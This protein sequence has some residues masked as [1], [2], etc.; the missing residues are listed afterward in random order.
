MSSTLRCRIPS[1]LFFSAVRFQLSSTLMSAKDLEKIQKSSSIYSTVYLFHGAGALSAVCRD[2]GHDSAPRSVLECP[3]VPLPLHNSVS[4]H[5]GTTFQ[6]ICG[7][8]RKAV[9]PPLAGADA[10]P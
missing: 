8:G 3:G 7:T 5:P 2:I 1:L 6:L 9:Q 4:S 10:V